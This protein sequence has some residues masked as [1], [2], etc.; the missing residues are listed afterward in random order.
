MTR[1]SLAVLAITTCCLFGCTHEPPSLIPLDGSSVNNISAVAQV[2]EDRDF[3][4]ILRGLDGVLLKGIRVQ[5]PFN[6]YTY[7]MQAG[8]HIF[9][10]IS[11]P[12]PHPL[13]PQRIRCYVIEATLVEGMKYR[14]VEEAGVKNALLVNDTT[15]ENVAI[16]KLVDEPWV[17]E[18]GCRWK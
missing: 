9:W 1:L 4:I 2:V 8:P 6:K 11:S 10:G 3:P 7:V 15:G 17:F 14:L 12:Y 5:T 16:G 18:R 13:I